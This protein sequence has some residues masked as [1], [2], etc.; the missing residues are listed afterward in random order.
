NATLIRCPSTRARPTTLFRGGTVPSASIET[1]MLP[2]R[3]GGATTGIGRDDAPPLPAPLAWALLPCPN[4]Y[5][6]ASAS[7]ASATAAA[8]QA[9]RR[10]RGPWRGGARRSF[11]G[12]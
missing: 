3:S 2:L 6:A 9:Q 8:I 1:S 4:Q 10:G 12:F 11:I 5:Q 7:T